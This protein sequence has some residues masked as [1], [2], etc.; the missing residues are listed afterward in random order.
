MV[1]FAT[2]V[3][4]GVIC[5]Y[6]PLLEVLPGHRGRGIGTELIR[7]LLQELGETYMVDVVCDSEVVAF[8][9]RLGFE[10][11]DAGMGIRNRGAL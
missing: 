3:G 5:A 6:I 4:D 10:Q 1:G 2:A 11:L 8:Y 7:M 9:Q